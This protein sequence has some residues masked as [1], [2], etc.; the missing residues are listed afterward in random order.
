MKKIYVQNRLIPL[1]SIQLAPNYQ[2]LHQGKK[3]SSQSDRNGE[4]VHRSASCARGLYLLHRFIGLPRDMTN[5][6]HGPPK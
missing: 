1:S 5:G 4:A 3:K 6:V 2:H